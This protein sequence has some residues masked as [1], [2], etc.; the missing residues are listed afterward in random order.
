MI[1][2]NVN[3]SGFKGFTVAARPAML[4]GVYHA[5]EIYAADESAIRDRLP[6]RWRKAWD[7]AGATW[8]PKSA[9]LPALCNDV[10]DN[11]R[12]Q[13]YRTLRDRRGRYLT[14]VYANGAPCS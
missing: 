13:G 1:Q 7:R 6:F 11:E 5:G 2:F 9:C 10:A 8:W 4:A 14:T 3:G 12:P